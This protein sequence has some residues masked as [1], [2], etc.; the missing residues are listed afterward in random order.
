MCRKFID[1]GL[2]SLARH[3]N[4]GGEIALWFGVFLVSA[5]ALRGGSLVAAAMSPA[6][7]AVLLLRVSGV[8]LLE[9]TAVKRWGDSPAYQVR[10]AALDHP[11][12]V[13]LRALSGA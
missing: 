2:W 6:F 3:P 8:P 5:S 7:V 1:S 4:Y 13:M 12:V 10:K 11:H 9:K